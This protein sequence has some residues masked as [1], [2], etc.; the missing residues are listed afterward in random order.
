G[1][2][3][4]Q[5]GIHHEDHFVTGDELLLLGRQPHVAAMVSPSR[6]GSTAQHP[7]LRLVL[8][9]L[10]RR[11]PEAVARLRERGGVLDVPAADRAT[12]EADYLPRLR[13]Q[14]PVT[15]SDGSVHLAEE[16]PPRL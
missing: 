12:F 14:L 1:G 3:R 10:Q 7:K 6:P 5:V 2:A 15:S 4:L 16:V 13:Q 9:P 8:A 11:L